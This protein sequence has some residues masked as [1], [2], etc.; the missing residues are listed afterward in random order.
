MLAKSQKAE[1][2]LD[3]Y[4]KWHSLP[5]S[6]A[7]WEDAALIQQKWPKKIEEF[8]EREQ[9]TRTPT[10]H[11]KILRYRPKFHEVKSQ[12]EYMMGTEKV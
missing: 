2:G 3:Y 11:C 9:S 10:R 6:D 7:T 1:G 5:Y 4:I 12:P 8:E